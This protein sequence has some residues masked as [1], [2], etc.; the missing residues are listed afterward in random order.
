MVRT[1]TQFLSPQ[2]TKAATYMLINNV[3]GGTSLWGAVQI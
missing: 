3:I 1:E 2:F